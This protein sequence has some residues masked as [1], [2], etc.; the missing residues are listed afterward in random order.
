MKLIMKNFKCYIDKTFDFQDRGITLIEG[1]SGV[2]KSTICS[3]IMFVLYGSGNK[4]VS[5]GK[6][7]CSV[8]L[9]Y[10]NLHITRTKKPNRLLLND[11]YEN[12]IA[13]SMINDKFG[14]TFDITGYMAQ[15][16]YSS[17]IMLNP[18]D[19]IIF[20]EKIAFNNINLQEIKEKCKEHIKQMND[21]LI[22][23]QG[24]IEMYK[25]IISELK[26]PE[27]INPP[28]KVKNVDIAI[29]NEEIK[30]L[31][32]VTRNKKA[33][34]EIEKLTAQKNDIETLIS[35]L[36]SKRLEIDNINAKKT[37]TSTEIAKLN[38]K[39][40]GK[41]ML[42]KYEQELVNISRNNEFDKLKSKIDDMTF[43][44][45]EMKINDDDTRNKEISDIMSVLW[46]E[47]TKEYLDDYI[48]STQSFISD[49]IKVES[50]E[51][52]KEKYKYD[53]SLI[54]FYMQQLS[55]KCP[56]CECHLI[57]DDNQQLVKI[58]CDIQKVDK[59]QKQDVSKKLSTQ[60]NNKVMYSEIESS[61]NKLKEQYSE[62]DLAQCESIKKEFNEYNIYYQRQLE[63]EIKL[64][65][66]KKS[67]Y[68][69]TISNFS[70]TIDELTKR[71]D[72]MIK[73]PVE[74]TE[75]DVRLFIQENKL[76]E[77]KITGLQQI[78]NELDNEFSICQKDID[79]LSHKITNQSDISSLSSVIE[80]LKSKIKSDEADYIFHQNNNKLLI[81]YKHYV[82]EMD[83]IRQ[84][85]IE[86]EELQK[87]EKLIL[88]KYTASLK[89]REKILE[90]ES[91]SIVNIINSINTH[92]QIYLDDF[93]NDTPISVTLK[94]FKET[95][96]S[97]KSQINVE[98][99]FKGMEYTIDML[100]GGELARVVLAF[101][102]AL[103]EM[104]NNP[105]IILDECT[106]NLDEENT[107]NII[108]SLKTHLKNKLVLM[109][110]HQ[111][112]TG[113]YDSVISLS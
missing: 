83:K 105:I 60:K 62:E 20:L 92:A 88:S 58:D 4:L 35:K 98:I 86:Y 18:T 74:N 40:C 41:D 15:N 30:A 38:E 3:A 12:D 85:T 78:L 48:S 22:F 112:E 51:K 29:K 107:N 103:G 11:I 55:L 80:E 46:K 44:L 91:L 53:D 108:M 73:L 36:T 10:E 59:N 90:S 34:K 76:L 109:I 28:F 75:S 63:L 69:Q 96:K 94:S 102:L 89:L 104:F 23:V 99:E 31:N 57:L 64:N 84:K 27:I 32:C 106:S 24:K 42:V 45:S 47:N 111:A 81:K 17:F 87:E 110:A 50:L 2:G 16:T 21:K 67:K 37:K 7:T 14:H 33:Q 5:N 70:T 95:K 93:F 97:I 52:Q 9:Y 19:K 68:S 8:E 13:Q 1:L 100:S 66:L 79:I 39:Y 101:T 49:M 61:I 65:H 56:G 25:K 43:Q 54:L 113:N 6:T 77:V 71:L 26:S 82:D 72:K